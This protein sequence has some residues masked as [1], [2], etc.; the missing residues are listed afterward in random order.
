MEAKLDELLASFK[1]LKDTQEAN[2][3]KMSEK[4][5]KLE[6]DVHAGQDTAAERVVKKLKRDRTLEFKKKGHE[7]QFLFN[8]EVK[9]RMESAATSLE[10][11]DPS[12]AAS[13]TALDDAKKE[14]EEGMQFIAQR[15]KL[16]RLADRSEYG[17]DA[18]NEYEKDELAEDDDDAKRLEKAEKAAEQKAFRKRRAAGRGGRGRARRPNPLPVTQ[19]APP[20]SIGVVQPPLL[21]Q[22]FSQPR[23]P[24]YRPPKIPGP[25]FNC[26]KM[27]HLK[28]NCPD[29]AKSYPLVISSGNVSSDCVGTSSHC[30]NISSDKDKIS[31]SGKCSHIRAHV[32]ESVQ[33]STG[34]SE[35][36]IVE[37]MKVRGPS[38]DRPQVNDNTVAPNE[39]CFNIASKVTQGEAKSVEPLIE[40]ANNPSTPVACSIELA[41]ADEALE[42]FREGR[43]WEVEEGPTQIQDVQGRL[44]MSFTFWKDILKASQPVLE[45]IS[46]GY[47]L[48]LLSVPTPHCRPNQRSALAEHDF[49]SAAVNELL[50]NRCIQKVSKV[51][52][53]C[54]PLSVVTNAEGKKRLVV[55]LRYLN[56]HLL[57]E[58]FKYE[59]MRMALLMSQPGDFMCSFDL[60]SGYHHIDIHKEHWQYLGFSW[61][62]NSRLEYYVF[63]V[64]P[65]GLA[66]ACFVFT[67]LMRPLVRHWRQQGIRI[68]VYLDDGL[69]I[70]EG[71]QSAVVASRIVQGDLA[72]AGWVEN[73]AKCNWEPAQQR[74]WLGFEVDLQEGIVSVPQGKLENLH[75]ELEYAK[76]CEVLHAKRLASLIG[77]LISM[78]LAIGPVTRL[79]TRSMY[80]LLNTRE[81]WCDSLTITVEAHK[82]IEFWC[83]EIERVN[84]Q[85]IW[86]SPSAIRVVYTDA[87]D[88]GYAGYT[89]E[90]GCHIAH[91]QW[92][93]QEA[94]QSST[95]RELRAVRRVLE[96]LV[97]KLRNQRVRWFTDNQNVSRIITTGSKKPQLQA[98]ALAI[99]SASVANNIRIEP[100]WIPRA[101]N[102]LADYL[103]CITDYDDWS[104]DH[105][106]FLSIDQKW[107]PHTVDRF[108]SHYNTQ[109]PRFNSRFWNPG[110]EA[111]DAFTSN[112]HDDNNWLCPPVYLVP[113]ILRHACNCDA[114]GTLVV[115]EWPSAVFWPM[116]FPQPDR[117]ATFVKEVITIWKS[118]LYLHPGKAGAN[119]FKGTP[120]TNMLAI[121]IDFQGK[122]LL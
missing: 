43:F 119:L 61:A 94:S 19:Q 115:P 29:L 7:R 38:D 33:S 79:M 53:I 72:S 16:I 68:I 77:K 74:I 12:T 5:E 86:P 113:R 117:P 36:D 58:K 8:D 108:A 27:G 75:V 76:E 92:L 95:W 97:T 2:Q 20:P 122:V 64:L 52:H 69:L 67:K 10:K 41:G 114:K 70:S 90:H 106:I 9:D 93:P 24:T 109:L 105:S 32:C 87:S 28:A 42:E 116:L 59:D 34:S 4:L 54:S 65:F 21:N 104:L 44:K 101:E 55:N 56:Q 85:N 39:R 15:Q 6:Q 18:V 110:T 83:S 45:W 103:S 60:K 121:Q 111:V 35:S 49:V 47:K 102:E 98:E 31:S 63:C 107:G 51:P 96:S 40:N 73:Q 78:S 30:G 66:T 11:V 13:K 3:Q 120:N 14:L 57:K 118:E 25:C 100:E 80:S 26:L 48:P 81:A 1:Q 82:E 84:G 99:Y 46:V 112:W 23:G 50:A 88:T 22:G 71:M 62:L 91:G 37:G 89:V 17:W